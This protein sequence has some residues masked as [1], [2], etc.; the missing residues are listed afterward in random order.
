MTKTNSLIYRHAHTYT[1]THT[2]THTYREPTYNQGGASGNWG[3]LSYINIFILNL[4][5][6]REI[7]NIQTQK[8]DL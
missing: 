7:D 5:E 4:K 8:K 1:H 3:V 6:I 2:H